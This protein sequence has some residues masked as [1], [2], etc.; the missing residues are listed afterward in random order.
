MKDLREHTAMKALAFIAAVAAFAAAAIMGWYQLA[1]YD[2]LW[3][4]DYDAGDSYSIYYLEQQDAIRIEDLLSL[5]QMREAGVD[6][7]VYQTREIARLE[8]DLDPRNTNLRW[9]LLS[10]GEE[11]ALLGGN[12]EETMPAQALGLYW[13]YYEP[14]DLTY[15]VRI[16]TGTAWER[17]AAEAVNV[18]D[19]DD[20]VYDNDWPLLLKNYYATLNGAETGEPLPDLPDGA[21]EDTVFLSADGTSTLLMVDTVEGTYLYGPSLRAVREANRFGYQ[22]LPGE[23]DWAQT[24]SPTPLLELVLWLDSALTVDDDYREAYLSLNQ[25]KGDRELLLGGTVACAALGLLLTVY[26]CVAAGHRR[27][28]EGISLNWFHRVPGDLLLALLGCGAAV[29]G[30]LAASVVAGSYGH[31]GLPMALQLVLMGLLAAAGTAMA[32]G[33]LLT[34][35]VRCKAHTLFC[36]TLIWRLCRAVIRAVRAVPLVWKALAFGLAYLLFTIL[37]FQYT[38]GLWLLGSGAALVLLGLWA[39][40]WKKIRRGT[41]EILSGRTDY[42]IDTARMLPDLKAHAEELNNLSQAITAAVDD[43][44]RSEHFK[45]E[46]ITNVS[47]DLKTPLTS[48]INYVDLLKKED[49]PSEAAR[50]YLDVLDRKSQRL[51]KLTEDLVEAS[52]ASTGSLPVHLERLGMVQLFQQAA[53]EFEERFAQSGLTLVPGFPDRELWVL[54]DGRHLWR[55]MDNLLSN[56]N[57]YALPGTRVY[58]DVFRREGRVVLTLKNVSRQ[59]LN[60]PAEQLMERFVRGDQARSTEGSGLGLSIARSLTELQGGQF[61]IEIDGDLFKAAVSFPEAPEPAPVP[62]PPGAEA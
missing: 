41:R 24:K 3:D 35:V 2:A 4:P 27:G 39:F 58:A 25:W 33:G 60:I 40:Q 26:L 30:A 51:K 16:S 7:S 34:V 36:N 9:Q 62:L 32:L 38:G 59:Q 29:A 37:T 23:G 10:G 5:Y 19:P 54:A 12:T 8:T 49:M 56:C 6:L 31:S 17:V 18:T 57:K 21:G 42:H 46:L 22:F 53:G 52:K 20:V 11:N 43:R 47:H 14:W 45:A 50:Q 44:M 61:G 15:G 13:T 48:I 28:R 1:N 55:V